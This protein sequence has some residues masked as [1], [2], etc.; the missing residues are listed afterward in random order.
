MN[1]GISL[2]FAALVGVG[3]A[4][5][6]DHL[7]AVSTMVGR[8]KT[9][10]ELAKSGFFW[11]L[12]HTSTIVLIG[13]LL[14]LFQIQSL[15]AYLGYFEYFVAIMLIGLGMI[16]LIQ[17]KQTPKLDHT[18]PHFREAYGIGLI[19]GLAGSG[20]LVLLVMSNLPSTE[21][22]L[23]Y[24]LL[25]GLGSAVGMSMAAMLMRLP[26]LERQANPNRKRRFTSLSACLC[27]AY[28]LIM[29]IRLS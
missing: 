6:A 14:I 16:R 7:L 15:T 22:A 10:R 5:E 2:I 19:H 27:I 9:N 20:A 24:L 26:L 1:G 12:G 13:I 17:L 3:H 25:F 28:G 4:F 18:H 21:E 8:S 29:L 23:L 11:G